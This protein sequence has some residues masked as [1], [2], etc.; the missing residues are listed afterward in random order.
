MAQQRYQPRGG[1]EGSGAVASGNAASGS[2]G[3]SSGHHYS[4]GGGSNMFGLRAEGYEL[5][6]DGKRR[7]FKPLEAMR[8]LFSKGKRKAKDEQVSVVAVKAKSTTALYH[9]DDDDDDDD[10][11]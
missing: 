1:G 9:H 3:A 6:G 5:K 2:A 4:S 10:G 11:G 8:K 7:K